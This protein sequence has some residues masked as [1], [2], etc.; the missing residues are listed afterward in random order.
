MKHLAALPLAALLACTGTEP[1]TSAEL[2]SI[3]GTWTLQ[4]VN[5]SP[6]PAATAAGT[7]TLRSTLLA[8]DGSFTI[9]STVRAI[10]SRTD[11]QSVVE[12]GSVYCGHAGCRPQLLL[13]RESGAEADALVEGSTLTVTRPDLVQVFL[14]R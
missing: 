10:G 4:S 13:F 8:G 11:P 2:N 3:Y 1:T 12:S 7:E 6:L 14:R 5:G 9:S